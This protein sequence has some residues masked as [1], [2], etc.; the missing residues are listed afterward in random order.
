KQEPAKEVQLKQDQQ[1]QPPA[2]DAAQDR[3]RR[4]AKRVDRLMVVAFGAMEL[5]DRAMLAARLRQTVQAVSAALAENG[6]LFAEL[7]RVA[8]RLVAGAHN[9]AGSRVSVFPPNPNTAK[10]P[11]YSVHSLPEW[12]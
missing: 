4:G 3:L 6:K 7:Q 11:L 12:G 1:H 5:E 9:H 2:A 10:L 8:W